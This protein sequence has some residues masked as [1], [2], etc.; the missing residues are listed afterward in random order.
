MIDPN[1]VYLAA[2]ITLLGTFVY[3]FDIMR[4]K[5]KP[6]RITWTLWTLIPLIIFFAQIAE[7]VGVA[8]I[9][10]LS[11]AVGPFIV[12]A[13]SF[14]NKHS[15]WKL[16]LFDYVCGAISLLAI[17]LWVITGDGIVDIVFSIIADF[18]ASIPTLRKGLRAPKT[19]SIIVYIVGIISAVITLL[20]LHS[21][22][23]A[24]A[25]FALYILVNNVLFYLTIKVF[26]KFHRKKP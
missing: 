3:A 13:T 7:G 17:I 23:L 16:T 14:A 10:T 24:K 18:A 1:F 15:Y 4:G 8:S 2:V 19:E 25:L 20:T 12:V 5:T 21:Y 11:Y 22:D 9:F 6:N 26:S